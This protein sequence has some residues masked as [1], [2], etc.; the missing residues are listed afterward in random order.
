MPNIVLMAPKD[1]NELQNMLHTA[2][3]HAGPV[4]LRY[5]RG[6]TIGASM[7]G[8]LKDLPIGKAE[9]IYRSNIHDPKIKQVVFALGS[10]VDPAIEAAELAEAKRISSTVVNAR[11]VKPLDADLIIELAKASDKVVT[12][13]EGVLEGG[14]GSAVAELL[15]DKGIEKPIN[16]IGLPSKFIEHGT[17]AQILDIYGLTAEKIAS[18]F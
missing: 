4:A 18:A 13:E 8:M 6:S 3:N 7:D 5:P 17:R 12:V 1:G 15:A 2:L 14:F 10:M 16:R 11:F 9:I